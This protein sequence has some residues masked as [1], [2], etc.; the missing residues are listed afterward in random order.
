MR[1]SEGDVTS[2]NVDIVDLGNTDELEHLFQ[3]ADMGFGTK[4]GSPLSIPVRT[5][6]TLITLIAWQ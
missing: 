5:L 6:I 3:D 2:S 1:L 4:D